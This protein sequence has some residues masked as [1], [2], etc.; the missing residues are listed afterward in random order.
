MIKM[1]KLMEG[2]FNYNRK[3]GESLPTLED[4]TKDETN[5]EINVSGYSE[6]MKRGRHMP[7]AAKELIKAL[8]KQHDRE[9]IKNINYI[10]DLADFLASRD[11]DYAS[12]EAGRNPRRGRGCVLDVAEKR[13]VHRK[14][15][16]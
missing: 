2:K 8:K 5:E 16:L 14:C 7:L 9:V 12:D 1:K 4:F 15:Y 10:A 3:F 11:A 6:L 13:L